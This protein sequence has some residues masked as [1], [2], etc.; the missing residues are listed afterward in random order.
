MRSRP[1]RNAYHRF[2]VDRHL[3]EA[4]ANAAALADRVDRPDLLVLGALFHDLGKG[5][6]GDHTT[7]GMA[8]VGEIGP[9]LGLGAR[10]RRRRSCAM[11]AAPPAAARRR[12]SGAT[13]TDPATIRKVADAVG[14]VETLD[15]LAR[16]HR[17]RLAGHRPVGVGLVEGAARRRPRRRAPATCS[18]AAT[19]SEVTGAHVPRRGDAGDDGGR[20]LRRA[21]RRR[22]RRATATG[23]ERITVVCDDVPGRVR[24][25]RRRAVAARPR[26]AHGVGVLRRA[27]AARPMAASQFRVVPPRGGRRLGAGRRGPRAAP[28]PASWRSRPGWPSGPA[29]T[30]GGGRCR[31]QPAGPPSVTFHDDASSDVDGDRGAGAEPRSACCTASPRRSPSS[32]STSATPRCRRSA[33]TSST[34]STCS[35]RN[36]RLDRPT[37]STAR[38]IERAV[39][40]AV[41][42]SRRGVELGW[43]AWQRRRA[44]VDA[45]GRPAFTRDLARWSETLAAIARTGL[46]FTENL[47]ERERFEEVLNVAA[48]I[49]AAANEVLG[50]TSTPTRP[51]R[52]R[53]SRTTSC[54]SGWSRSASACPAT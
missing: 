52:S 43:P 11:V 29:R 1:Q 31:P 2:T 27:R 39:L 6:P 30:A 28:S 13:S 32:A 22:R 17:G 14:D 53:A 12:R 19:P 46:G 44:D 5:Y 26:R 23:T 10:R 38:E 18:T 37:R 25:H 16:P 50:S 3:W 24:P 42:L 49:K 9:R 33:R 15:L 4:A 47:Y 8:L 51:S 21:H 36:G 40:H 35:G 7:A 20:P 41:V 54:R 34:R 48:D 45:T